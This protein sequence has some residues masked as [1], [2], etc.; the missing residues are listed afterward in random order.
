MDTIVKHNLLQNDEGPLAEVMDKVPGLGKDISFHMYAELKQSKS[1]ALDPIEQ[2]RQEYNG[3]QHALPVRT[4]FGRLSYS[5][6][7]GEMSHLQG[8]ASQ[9]YL[10]ILAKRRNRQG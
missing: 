7:P 8:T 6:R 4:S 5:R 10:P 9:N 3:C 2:E 1:V